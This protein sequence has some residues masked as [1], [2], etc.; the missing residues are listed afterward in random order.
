MRS[1]IILRCLVAHSFVSAWSYLGRVNGSQ[2]G[3]SLF[4]GFKLNGEFPSAQ[5]C[6]APRPEV[7][8]TARTTGMIIAEGAGFTGERHIPSYA[9]LTPLDAGR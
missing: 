2:W 1:E 9:P 7:A 6:F 8:G 4:Q 5:R 3:C